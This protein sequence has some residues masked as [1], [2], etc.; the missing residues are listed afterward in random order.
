VILV[1]VRDDH[2][3]HAQG[4]RG[5]EDRVPRPVKPGIDHDAADDVRADVQANRSARTALK[6]EA[7]DVAKS[8]HGH[9]VSA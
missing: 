1:P 5:V 8:L 3:A 9:H 7:D 6:T 2:A 4:T